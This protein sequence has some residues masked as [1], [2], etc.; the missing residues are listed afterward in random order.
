VAVPYIKV[1]GSKDGNLHVF[2]IV[3]AKWVLENII[4]RK[5]VIF[6]AARITSKYLLK[7]RLLFP[8]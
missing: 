3:N 8:T 4:L 7:H 1:E 5:M 2:E 6:E